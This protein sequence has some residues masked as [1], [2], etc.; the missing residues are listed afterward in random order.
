MTRARRLPACHFGASTDNVGNEHERAL[1]SALE[2][3]AAPQKC[4]GSSAYPSKRSRPVLLVRDG[5]EAITGDAAKV[6]HRRIS[7][8]GPRR[9]WPPLCDAVKRRA[10]RPTTTSATRDLD[11]DACAARCA[12]PSVSYR[13][14]DALVS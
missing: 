10:T 2:A 11:L 3:I 1:R 13:L 4:D 12:R 14:R 9:H 5:H 7:F 8:A 6:L